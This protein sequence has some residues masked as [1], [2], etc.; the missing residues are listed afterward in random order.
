MAQCKV[1]LHTF[2]NS[3]L[4]AGDGQFHIGNDLRYPLNRMLCGHKDGLFGV[5]DLYHHPQSTLYT[6]GFSPWNAHV[7]Y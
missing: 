5:E 2:L 6:V 1:W 4:D 3:I 7:A